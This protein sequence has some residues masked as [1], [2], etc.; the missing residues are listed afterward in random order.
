MQ[1]KAFKE[2]TVICQA[3]AQGEQSLIIRK[4]GI[5][6]GKAGFSFE[7]EKFLLFPTYFHAQNDKVK[8]AQVELRAEHQLGDQIELTHL[9]QLD[10]VTSIADWEKVQ[11]LDNFHIWSQETIRERFDWEKKSDKSDSLISNL[12]HVAIVRIYELPE[13]FFMTYERSHHGCKSWIDIDG[14]PEL[15]IE[16]AEPVINNQQYKAKLAELKAVLG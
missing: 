10:Y 3:L 8:S 7:A 1:I 11:E 9:A 5:S 6:E 14:V 4:G 15:L 12:I 16:R 13:P 2:W